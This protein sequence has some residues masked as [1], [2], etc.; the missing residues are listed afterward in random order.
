MFLGFTAYSYMSDTVN[1][2]MTKD[3]NSQLVSPCVSGATGPLEIKTAH[4][5]SSLIY[6]WILYTI[7]VRH[8]VSVEFV[9]NNMGKV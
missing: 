7:S 3:D 6:S 9:P 8:S 5:H 1:V 4:F 2:S